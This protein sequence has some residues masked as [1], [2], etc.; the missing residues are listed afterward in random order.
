[1]LYQ[2]TVESIDGVDITT[3]RPDGIEVD[4]ITEGLREHSFCGIV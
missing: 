2:D 1:M 3:R 4:D